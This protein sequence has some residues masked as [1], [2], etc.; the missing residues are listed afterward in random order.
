MS[1]EPLWLAAARRDLGL[2]EIVGSRDEPRI[3]K[4]FAEAGH[5]YV[6][7]DETAWC[8][9]FVN[10]KLKEAGVAG[11][12]KLNARSFLAWGQPRKTPAPGAI[13]VF[14]RGNSAWQ[15]H[16]AFYL[17][18][19]GDKIVVLG[20]NQANSVSEA[21]YAKASLLGYRWAN[22]VALPVGGPAKPLK[23]GLPRLQI[24]S[25]GIDVRIWQE[26]LNAIG[27]KPK[28][29]PDGKFGPMTR[30]ATAAFQR[31]Q[32]LSDDGVVEDGEWNAAATALERLG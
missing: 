3:V 22:G 17:G 10:A 31:S 9:A 15:G 29:D 8:A 6:K 7:D 21:R 5:P 12:G 4:F 25:K 30:D 32:Q 11:T 2:R 19:A 18:D 13:V 14:K 28:L 1:L 26:Q 16:V 24:G 27:A 20:G 23:G